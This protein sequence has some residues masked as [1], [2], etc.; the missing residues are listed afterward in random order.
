MAGMRNFSVF[1]CVCSRAIAESPSTEVVVKTC[2]T[3]NAI[4]CALR[5]INFVMAGKKQL[6]SYKKITKFI[7]NNFV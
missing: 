4:G 1:L 3:S 7:T 5:N 6:C 2:V